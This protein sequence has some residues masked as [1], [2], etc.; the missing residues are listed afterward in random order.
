MNI[1]QKPKMT[2]WQR[3]STG[4]NVSM[5]RQ[6]PM[7]HTSMSRMTRPSDMLRYLLTAAAMM[8]VPPVEPLLRKTTASDVPVSVQ[9][10]TSDMKSLPSPMSL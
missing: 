5:K 6:L 4:P 10:M 3:T 1:V 7:M 9:P 2:F 8:S